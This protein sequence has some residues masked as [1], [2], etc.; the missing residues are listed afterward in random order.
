MIIYYLYYLKILKSK[1]SLTTY[2]YTD[3]YLSRVQIFSVYEAPSS[4]NIDFFGWEPHV[5]GKFYV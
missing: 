4:I 1:Y 3:L 2:I 5:F